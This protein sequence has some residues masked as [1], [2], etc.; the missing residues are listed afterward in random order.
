M[1]IVYLAAALLMTAVPG[2]CALNPGVLTSATVSR[3]D[4]LIAIDA[5]NAVE[6][7]ATAAMSACLSTHSKAGICAPAVVARVHTA[8]VAARG[9]RDQL[10][11]FAQQHGDAQLGVTG[12]YDA[13]VATKDSLLAILVQ[14]GAAAA[15]PKPA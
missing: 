15:P 3:H 9:P 13:V 4:V 10:N 11:T 6:D 14:Y 7:T 8:L 5:S 2:A 1:R 12:L